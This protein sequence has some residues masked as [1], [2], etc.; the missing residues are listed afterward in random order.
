[1]IN[2]KKN[3][4]S[5]AGTAGGAKNSS[6]KPNHG[7]SRQDAINRL[8]SKPK[9]PRKQKKPKKKSEAQKDEEACAQIFRLMQEKVRIGLM[10]CVSGK[11]LEVLYDALRP[12]HQQLW[13]NCMEIKKDLVLAFQKTYP[14]IRLEVFGSTVMGIAFK[15]NFEISKHISF[16]FD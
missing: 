2:T 14:S 5:I 12:N 4:Y 6:M 15:G 8:M 7:N 16:L 1:M 3:Y 9:K 10:N 13:Q 11:E